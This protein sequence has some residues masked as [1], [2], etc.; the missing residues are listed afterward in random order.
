MVFGALCLVGA[1]FYA[2]TRLTPLENKIKDLNQQVTDLNR[3]KNDMILVN[4]KLSDELKTKQEMLTKLKNTLTELEEA[5]PL[6]RQ[7]TQELFRH[8]YLE[9]IDHYGQF[10]KV[11][12]D[13]P[14]ALNFL[15]YAEYRYATSLRDNNSEESKYYSL[16][17]GHL[18]ES[19]RLRKT[20]MDQF[21]FASYNLALVYFKEDKKEL[22]LGQVEQFLRLNPSTVKSLC[23]DGQFRKLHHDRD[24]GKRFTEVVNT[25]SKNSGLSSCWLTK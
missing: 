7:G 16:A 18:K 20:S 6:I 21:N 22:S 4:A 14:E 11:F 13:S 2:G 19:V 25:A 8:Q 1:L 9:S 17:E 12:P 23:G 24:I 10:L 5:L 15:G 3:Q